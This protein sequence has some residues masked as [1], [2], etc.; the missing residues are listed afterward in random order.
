MVLNKADTQS[1]QDGQHEFQVRN[2]C[3]SEEFGCSHCQHYLH[4]RIL[5]L[6][7]LY[8][9]FLT[10]SQ[11]DKLGS[12]HKESVELQERIPHIFTY[13][14]LTDFRAAVFSFRMCGT[15]L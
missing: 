11:T 9:S 14:Q 3:G 10:H 12:H 13:S 8:C 5:P 1:W 4:L 7:T 6:S 15:K 2:C